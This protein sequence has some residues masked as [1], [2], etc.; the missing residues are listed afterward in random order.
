MSAG[1]QNIACEQCG[2]APTNLLKMTVYYKTD[3]DI[4][5]RETSHRLTSTIY[6]LECP[7]C[8]WRFV[9]ERLA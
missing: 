1:Q 3:I 7:K 6:D 2:H 9:V 4:A 8:G 5:T